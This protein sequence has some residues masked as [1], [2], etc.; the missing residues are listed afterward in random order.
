MWEGNQLQEIIKEKNLKVLAELLPEILH[1]FVESF[2]LLRILYN[3]VC[4]KSVEKEQLKEYIKESRQ[5]IDNFV[6]SFDKLNKEFNVSKTPKFHTI[7]DHILDYIELTGETLGSLDQCIEALHQYV[8][9]RMNSSNYKVKTVTKDI[10]GT[11]LMQCVLHINTYN[12][13]N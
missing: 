6:V 4:K 1:P 5:V 7:K 3:T 12:L 11:R 8:N 2:R 10:A 9:Q 13:Y